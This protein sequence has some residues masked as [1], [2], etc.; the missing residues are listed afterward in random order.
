[1]NGMWQKWHSWPLLSAPLLTLLVSGPR[2][3]EAWSLL[4]LF[5]CS[6]NYSSSSTQIWP[7][8]IA[9]NLIDHYGLS[10]NWSLAGLALGAVGYFILLRC[11]I[12]FPAICNLFYTP[13]GGLYFSLFFFSFE[14][15]SASQTKG[16]R[17]TE[18]ER[19][20]CQLMVLV[21]PY[22]NVFLNYG[23]S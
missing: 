5:H 18:R 11:V 19:L 7:H 13:N 8:K 2:N 1:M 15:R 20:Y 22:G 3:F 9:G 4:Y 21:F 10:G 23:P 12:R 16:I 6:K 14:K 17:C